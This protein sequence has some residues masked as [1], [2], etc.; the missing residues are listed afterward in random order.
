MIFQRKYSL[1]LLPVL[2]LILSMA[3]GCGS[4]EVAPVDADAV[5]KDLIGKVWICESL[6]ERE[7]TGDAK[8]TLEFLPDGTVKGSGGCND[9]TGTY[10][11]AGESLTFGPLASAKK[12]CGPAADEQEY[13]YTTFLARIKKLKVDGDELEL[14]AESTPVPMAFSTGG[15]GLFW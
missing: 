3:A 4:K 12:S 15:G 1:F 11:L 13:T 14:F 9:F 7:V 6:F 5:R 10:S 8:L 2:L